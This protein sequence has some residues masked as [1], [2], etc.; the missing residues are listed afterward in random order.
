MP[1]GK[2]WTNEDE[3]K[4]K[5]LTGAGEKADSIA[6]KLGKTPE[7]VI[8]KARRMNIEV[9]ETKHYQLTSSSVQLPADLPTPEEALRILAGAL[10]A[11]TQPGLNR[12]EVQR[13]QVLSRIARAYDFLLSNFIQYRQ[14]ETK[15][16]EL[17]RKYAQ[18]IQRK[19][20]NA[21]ARNDTIPAQP[22]T[23]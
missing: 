20:N 14:I 2:P 19:K 7:A 22:Q 10:K 17:E 8:Q 3:E 15:L 6:A 12:I 16:V 11:A 4:L 18:L 21:P 13:L 23:Q 1:K 5:Q 9:E